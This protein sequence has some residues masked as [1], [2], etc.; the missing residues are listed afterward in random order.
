MTSVIA[1]QI[2]GSS[3]GNSAR[4]STI[5]GLPPP[6]GSAPESVGID[7]SNRMPV[8]CGHGGKAN[9]HVIQFLK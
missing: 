9:G 4:A 1:Q 5:P 7:T 8:G 3:T 6:Y 2:I